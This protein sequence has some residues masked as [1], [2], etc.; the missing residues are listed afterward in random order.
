GFFPLAEATIYLAAAPKSNS[1]GSA[2]GR[3]LQDAQAT[4]SEPVPLHLRNAVT[5]LMKGMGYGA[6]YQYDHDAEDHYSGQEH[7]PESL[8]GR[9]YYTP[10]GQ[11]AEARI[12]EW[13]EKLRKRDDA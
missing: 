4:L 6:D 9:R 3:A 2:Y 8:A 5:P 12:K 13:L 10:T 11:G 1:V 7:L